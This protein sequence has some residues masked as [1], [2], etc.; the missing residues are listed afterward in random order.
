M[1]KVLQVQNLS[2]SYGSVAAV[3]GL[4]LSV[5]RGEVFGLLGPNGAGKSTSIECMLGVKKASAGTVEI[6]GINPSEGRK[7]LF[8]RV[9]VQFQETGYQDKIRVEEVCRM[10]AALYRKP[11]DWQRLLAVFDIQGLE[12]QEVSQLSGGERQRLSVLLALIPNPEL[13]FLDELTTGLDTRARREV[14]QYLKELKKGGLT[15]VLTSHFMDEVEVLC[16]RAL[17]LK[18]GEPQICGTI[19]EITEGSPCSCFEE[20]YLWYTGGD[21]DACV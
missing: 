4:S 21:D 14:W 13:V 19:E 16:D 17:I 20:A 18:K 10:T 12:K 9:G 15:I 5:A 11:A 8:E 3:S 2:K 1:E 7:T 6:L